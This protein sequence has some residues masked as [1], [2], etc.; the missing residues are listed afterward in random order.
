[1]SSFNSFSSAT[2]ALE[3]A[4]S[5]AVKPAL[6]VTLSSELWVGLCSVL[7][8]LVAADS[9][10]KSLSDSSVCN[11]SS[12]SLATPT[13]ASEYATEDAPARDALK[14]VESFFFCFDTD[15]SEVVTL[16]LA[17]ALFVLLA[18]T[19]TLSLVSILAASLFFSLCILLPKCT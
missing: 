5:S 7:W 10:S 13:V 15:L 16:G 19:F 14:I 18:L 1:M 17:E 11:E 8:S 2:F 9:E 3:L 12:F 6:R 4:L